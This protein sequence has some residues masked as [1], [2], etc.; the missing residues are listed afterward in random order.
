MMSE[1]P[2]IYL[3]NW[4]SH[5]TP[6]HHGPGRKYTIMARPRKWERGEGQVWALTPDTDALECVRNG[7]WSA[8]KYR[9]ETIEMFQRHRIDPSHLLAE[10]FTPNTRWIPVVGGDTLCCACSRAKAAAGECHRVWA[11]ELLK[12]AGWHVVLDGKPLGDKSHG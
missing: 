6:G 9:V 4:S 1:L 10:R 11:A 7:A 2:T 3:S 5:K 8:D 12:E